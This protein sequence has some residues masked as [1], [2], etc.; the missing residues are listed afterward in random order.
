MAAETEETL[1]FHWGKV[2]QEAKFDWPKNEDAIL[3][4]LSITEPT[5]FQQISR[6]FTI[7][8]AQM[9]RST[10]CLNAKLFFMLSQ[11]LYFLPP[12]LSDA[13]DMKVILD[14]LHKPDSRSMRFFQKYLISSE[15]ELTGSKFEMYLDI[16]NGNVERLQEEKFVVSVPHWLYAFLFYFDDDQKEKLSYKQQAQLYIAREIDRLPISNFEHLDLGLVGAQLC[17]HMTE[18]V[19][20]FEKERD[21][22]NRIPLKLVDFFWANTKK[23]EDNPEIAKHFNTEDPEMIPAINNFLVKYSSAL[24]LVSGDDALNFNLKRVFTDLKENV[25]NGYDFSTL[26]VVFAK[27]CKPTLLIHDAESLKKPVQD[28]CQLLYQSLLKTD[29]LICG[30]EITEEEINLKMF[31]QRESFLARDIALAMKMQKELMDEQ[32]PNATNKPEMLHAI[33]HM[34][35]IMKSRD[36][37]STD[38]FTKLLVGINPEAAYTFL[39]AI[40]AGIDNVYDWYLVYKGFA[41][42]KR[43]VGLHMAELKEEYENRN[44]AASSS[45]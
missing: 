34:A 27:N 42:S 39:F 37:I 24:D 3:F 14:E 5:S 25:E 10:S 17:E 30:H 33:Q 2:L 36:K 23:Y 38:E 16:I 29:K 9:F 28:T 31:S 41:N 8:N 7:K 40:Y 26:P 21:M 18:I 15:R 1:V 43:F 12:H 19:I 32:N 44:K 13:P 6:F 22:I 4:K 20:Y 35:R 45:E 11:D